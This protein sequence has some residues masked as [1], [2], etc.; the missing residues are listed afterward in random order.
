MKQKIILFLLLFVEITCVY[1]YGN[2]VKKGEHNAFSVTLSVQSLR[3][4]GY[5]LVEGPADLLASFQ[6]PPK[7]YGNVPF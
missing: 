5:P 2:I 3:N 1:S 7:G 4:N 6:N